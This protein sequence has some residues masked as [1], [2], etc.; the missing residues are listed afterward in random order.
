VHL[1]VRVLGIAHEAL[2]ARINE[3][4]GALEEELA[5]ENF[6]AHDQAV[7]D[8]LPPHELKLNRFCHR[9]IVDTPVSQDN[10]LDS[11]NTKTE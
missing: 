8:G 2:A 1:P 5:E 7:L 3:E 10:R 11:V 9:D 6:V 4:I